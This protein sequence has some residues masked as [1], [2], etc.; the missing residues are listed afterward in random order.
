MLGWTT[1]PARVELVGNVF[2]ANSASTGLSAW[3]RH[4]DELHMLNNVF[5][6]SVHLPINGVGA[7]VLIDIAPVK[8]DHNLWWASPGAYVEGPVA[9]GPN[10]VFADPMFVAPST[11]CSVADFGLL[12][13]SPAIDAGHPSLLD[14]DGT[15][16][17]IGG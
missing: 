12:P 5:G 14:P 1:N 8:L 17:D 15:V 4:V 13:G 7:D 6:A 10:A 9:T 2:W 11:D 3:F 16:S